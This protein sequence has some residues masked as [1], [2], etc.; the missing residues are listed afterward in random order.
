M[1]I[2]QE[3]YK[4][5]LNRKIYFIPLLIFSI[6]GYGFSLFNRTIGWDDLLRDHYFGDIA[7]A[8]RWGEALWTKLL[9]IQDFDPFIDRFV[10]L[11]FLIIASIL[12]SF[13]IYLISRQKS[14]VPY[15]ITSSI[16]VTY[17]LINEIWEYSGAN[18][19]V[20]GGLALT[21]LTLCI[22]RN[23]ERSIK[24]ML[25]S[26]ILLILPISS[27]ESSIFYYIALVFM[28]LFL[29][30]IYNN[31]FNK[32]KS[33]F[34]TISY[35][36]S[37]VVFAFFVRIIVSF[38]LRITYNLSSVGGGATEITWLTDP[39]SLVLLKFFGINFLNY[40]LSSLV[41]FPIT[42]FLIALLIFVG[43][44]FVVFYEKKK[45]SIIVYSIFLLLS[46]FSQAI[47]QGFGMPYRTAQT[48]TLFM[49][50]VSFLVA[51]NSMVSQNRFFRFIICISL[52]SVCWYQAVFLN[53]ILGLNNLRSENES[54]IL[55]NIGERIVRD[56]DNKPVVL[57]SPYSS[58]TWIE[59]RV[60][61]GY[62]T[63]NERL[64]HAVFIKIMPEQYR[65]YFNN[66]IVDSNVNCATEEYSQISA[67]FAYY[68]YDI[69]V[70][71]PIE[72]PHTPDYLHKDTKI[73]K[74][75]MAIAKEKN[76][77]PYEIYDNGEYL[78]VNL[79]GKRSFLEHEE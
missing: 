24:W 64:Y 11:L 4:D 57:I 65:K 9:G 44:V 59:S 43:F 32:E 49:S 30:N 12:F 28:V 69:N 36:L 31:N 76:M 3:Y 53:H 58:G 23:N 72:K 78:I 20:T 35:Y 17:P 29:D 55:R 33:F 56:Y 79:S 14:V 37:P 13:L 26:S 54:Y 47:L 25:V 66:R 16:F 63:W 7:L 40:F 71:G 46:L 1:S 22:L 19:F 74:E 5:I 15:T 42:E 75:A 60:E 62:D 51:A 10:A 2:V 67:A 50:L 73:L 68:G 39:I 61:I 8:G 18:L 6:V 41:Y 45:K 38:V 52:F 34:C 27:Y 77:R 21:T 70:V 48:L